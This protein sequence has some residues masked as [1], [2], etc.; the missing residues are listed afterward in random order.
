MTAVRYGSDWFDVGEDET[1]LDALLGQGLAIPHA[2]RKGICQT[3]LMRAVSGTPP[4]AAQQGLRET[5]KAGQYFLACVCK[6]ET[7]M[8]VVLPDD[9]PDPIVARVSGLRV[10]SADILE[11]A[12]ET[13]EP[14]D[15]HPGQFVRLHHPDGAS[16]SYSLASVPGIDKDLRLHV[17]HQA[18]GHVSGW[19][20]GQLRVG[21]RL[22]LSG[23]LGHCFYLPGRAADSLLLIGTG[24]GLA[25]LYGV[26]RQAL[27]QGHDGDIHLFH[28][29]R[30][31][32]G[33]YLVDALRTLAEDHPR[34]HYTPCLSGT[35]TPPGYVK[36][37]AEAVALSR[38]PR[39]DGWRV[40]LCG[41]PGMVERARVQAFLA[42][43]PL[44]DIYADPF[45]LSRP[46]SP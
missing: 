40:F 29:S 10:L 15:Y 38:H 11:V 22:K 23:P 42:G 2:C 12:L 19:I 4:A 5:H 8:A 37:R 14:F 24:S 1:V 16:R 20:H 34:F 32:E 39:L 26:A 44:T 27:H 33:L 30:E 28:G 35:C 45:H 36:G 17:R 25:P 21:D 7:E 43:A 18:N 6:P 31:P 3:C 13:T 46:A 9:L 41:H